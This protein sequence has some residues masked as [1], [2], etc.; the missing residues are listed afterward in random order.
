MALISRVQNRSPV[1][2]SLLS[3]DFVNVFSLKVSW[4]P[5][6]GLNSLHDFCHLSDIEASLLLLTGQEWLNVIMWLLHWGNPSPVQQQQGNVLPTNSSSHLL[7]SLLILPFPL[8][9]AHSYF[10]SPSLNQSSDTSADNLLPIT[11]QACLYAK[12]CSSA[13]LYMQSRRGGGHTNCTPLFAY[14][15]TF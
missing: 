6:S 5:P 14:E 3:M 7:S 8:F 4:R 13:G 2:H 12:T 11:V 10:S 9:F 15:A 1:S